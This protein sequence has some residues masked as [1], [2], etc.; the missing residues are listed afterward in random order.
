MV[1]DKGIIALMGSG[2]LTS[3]M[4]EVHKVLLS[5]LGEAPTATFLDTP[6]GFQLNAD[7]ISAHAV[8]YFAK[9]VGVHL[10]I[11]SYKS[12][13]I[14]EVDAALAFQR[15][16]KS[17][18][19]F[20]GPGSPTYLIDQLKDSPVPSILAERICQGGCLVAASAAALVMGRY[21]LPVYEIYK[22]G[23]PLHWRMGLDL[24][25]EFG[26][27]L[28]VVPHW[29]NMEGGTHDT[30]RCF[31]G[32]ARFDLLTARL[33][34][35]VPILG[36]DEHTAC[37][38]DFGNDSFQIRGAGSVSYLAQGCSRVFNSG[39][40]YPLALLRGEE[41]KVDTALTKDSD[42]VHFSNGIDHTGD[43]GKHAHDL[44]D[45]FHTALALGDS[46]GATTALLALDHL[47]WTGESKLHDPEIIARYLELF[48]ELLVVIGLRPVVHA[49]DPQHIVEPMVES[50]LVERQRLRNEGL[51]P[52]ADALR[53][54]LLRAGIVVE[55]SASGYRWR[56][57]PK[58]EEA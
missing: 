28:V 22:V 34:E 57:D 51:W 35:P 40:G 17:D 29:N 48:R 44:E 54:A 55:D 4:V 11:A 38:I 24:L 47:L 2:E 33:D 8:D 56:L 25:R 23:Q 32:K 21:T 5:R 3:T 39:A 14:E 16:R 19:I 52:A 27:S 37:I 31:M 36:L 10:D 41:Q 45:A 6:A 18:Y 46:R 20:M 1:E 49:L 43:F 12:R 13:I 53:D 26:L 58:R 42:A 15:L 50:L 7:Q 30:S 9:R